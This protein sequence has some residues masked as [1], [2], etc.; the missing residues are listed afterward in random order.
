V[1]PE[2]DNY[3]AVGLMAMDTSGAGLPGDTDHGQSPQPESVF[4]LDAQ[5][6]IGLW[7][8]AEFPG[9]ADIVPAVEVR[10]LEEGAQGSTVEFE[11]T[12]E[13]QIEAVIRGETQGVPRSQ[14]RSGRE[15]AVCAL[16]D[17]G[18]NSGRGPAAVILPRQRQVPGAAATIVDD[19]IEAMPLVPV[20]R[21]HAAVDLVLR[22]ASA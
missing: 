7:Q 19:E 2:G 3:E 10:D 15:R 11:S 18:L 8:V 20:P 12:A 22:P 16:N 17:L 13:L 21:D 4:T 1:N 5:R 9:A 14:D 6:P